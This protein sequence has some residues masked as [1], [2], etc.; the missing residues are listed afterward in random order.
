MA[1]FDVEHH[2]C[3]VLI[4]VVELLGLVAE[5][6]PD[7]D[8]AVEG[9]VGDHRLEPDVELE[10]SGGIGL[11]QGDVVETSPGAGLGHVP[12]HGAVKLKSLKTKP[13]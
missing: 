12:E 7:F 1:I 6:G 5:L 10:E 9:L 13:G 11:V 4:I 8:D 3:N 2:Q